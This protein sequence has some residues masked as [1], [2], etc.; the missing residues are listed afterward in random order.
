MTKKLK[1]AVLS[2]GAWSQSAHLPALLGDGRVEVVALS[3]PNPTTASALAAQFGVPLKTT[4]WRE[5]LAT[6]PDIVVVS[7]PPVAHEEQVVA[8]LQ[9]GAHVLVEKPFALDAATAL[10]MHEA[11]LKAG[12]HLLV[13]FGWPAAPIFS[14]C[15]ALIEAGEIGP[16]EHLT[17]H[18]AVNVRAL[19][20]G[21]NDGGWGGE[22]A[23]NAPTYTDPKV[24]GGGTAAVSMSH[25][26][27]LIEWLIGEQIVSVNAATFPPGQPIDLHCTVN[28]VFEGG[29]SAA[30]SS[31]ATH[32]YLARPQWTMALYGGKGQ[33]WADSISDT[34]R[35]VRADGTTTTWGAPEAS[36][37]YDEGA[38]T[39]ALIACGFGAPPPAGLSSALAA[40]VVAVT[41]GIYQSAKSAETIRIESK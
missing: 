36:G 12:R 17:M 20:A 22:L 24:S 41:D 34:L 18:L 31:A 21:G 33:L 13:G 9:S 15:R 5:A 2:A 40:H 26:L 37:L 39:K 4:D 28:A 23:S 38:P 10:R 11:S 19:L 29:G 8:A 1:A 14:R 25:Q 32:P 30:I 3:S 7:S 16:V 35:L 27:G 6:G